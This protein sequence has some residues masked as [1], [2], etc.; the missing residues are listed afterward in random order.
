[1]YTK[2]A[3]FIAI[4]ESNGRINGNVDG[5]VTFVR[6]AELLSERILSVSQEE[7]GGIMVVLGLM[8]YG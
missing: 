2:P 4:S 7:L 5:P 8:E 6:G 1:M 3:S